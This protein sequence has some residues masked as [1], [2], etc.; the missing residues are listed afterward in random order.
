MRWASR[1]LTVTQKPMR[2]S[3]SSEL[4]TSF[5]DER[6]TS[7]PRLLQQMKL[8][9]IILNCRQNNNPWIGTFLSHPRRKVLNVTVSGQCHFHYLLELRRSDSCGCNAEREDSYL[10][11]LHQEVDRTHKA[12]WMSLA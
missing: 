12:F 3:I 7:H 10:Q 5:E 1:S 9:F 11:H 4:L 2:K 6:R 8:G